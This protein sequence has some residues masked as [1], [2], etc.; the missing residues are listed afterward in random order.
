[1]GIGVLGVVI[2]F[3]IPSWD[4]RELRMSVLVISLLLRSDF[5]DSG[6]LY[7]EKKSQFLLNTNIV[8]DPLDM[9]DNHLKIISS[10]LVFNRPLP[11]FVFDT[12][13]PFIHSITL[14]QRNLIGLISETY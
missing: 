1:M 3:P 10:L 14:C 9:Q 5:R 4:W 8:I 6:K 12:I 7:I 2:T 11:D 13:T